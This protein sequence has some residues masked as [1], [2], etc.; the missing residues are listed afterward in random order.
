MWS[1]QLLKLTSLLL[2][3]L[4]FAECDLFF[5]DAEWE[6]AVKLLSTFNFSFLSLIIFHRETLYGAVLL[7]SSSFQ[8]PVLSRITFTFHSSWSVLGSLLLWLEWK[9]KSVC[10]DVTG[11][12]LIHE[13]TL[14]LCFRHVSFKKKK[15]LPLYSSRFWRFPSET[16]SIALWCDFRLVELHIFPLFR[17]FKPIQPTLSAHFYSSASLKPFI[18]PWHCTVLS[19]CERPHTSL[20]CPIAV[21]PK[22]AVDSERERGALHLS[23][24]S[25]SP[26]PHCPTSA[27][28]PV[29]NEWAH[30]ELPLWA[31]T[32]V[33]VVHVS[34][35]HES[36]RLFL[37]QRRDLW[38]LVHGAL[39]CGVI[40]LR[41]R[42][43]SVCGCSVRAK[44]AMF[45]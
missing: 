41:S 38:S 7:L 22:V 30:L 3:E 21:L 36:T 11:L 12:W 42:T 17:H 27:S 44:V 26:T 13:N 2:L 18:P 43:S 1:L 33:C 32:E 19:P 25:V 14:R 34:S 9:H 29:W 31:F 6:P 8:S 28:A 15:L 24:R 39:V 35:T 37:S 23:S 4:C 45:F 20:S 16:S 10:C 5:Y 40:Y